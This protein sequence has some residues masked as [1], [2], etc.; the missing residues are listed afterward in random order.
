MKTIIREFDMK[1][2]IF[3]ALFVLA[4][5]GAAFAQAGKKVFRRTSE[6][7]RYIVVDVTESP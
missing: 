1:Q 2:T 3:F 6:S 7:I 5:A 4:A